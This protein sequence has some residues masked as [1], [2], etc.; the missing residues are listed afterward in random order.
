MIFDFNHEAIYIPPWLSSNKVGCYFCCILLIIHFKPY[1]NHRSPSVYQFSFSG[2][3][4]QWY[5]FD[6]EEVKQ[7]HDHCKKSFIQSIALFIHDH[8]K[9]SFIQSIALFI[10]KVQTKSSLHA[11]VVE[12]STFLT[13]S[14]KTGLFWSDHA[15]VD[16]FRCVSMSNIFT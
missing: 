3:F 13:H 1:N 7:N 11:M 9:K 2:F 16:G 4:D 10:H 15:F 5:E 12:H 6:L 8:C 14:W